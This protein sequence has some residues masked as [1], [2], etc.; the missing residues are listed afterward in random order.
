VAEVHGRGMGLVFAAVRLEAG[1]GRPVRDVTVAFE[2]PA[3]ADLFAIE[4]GWA[5]YVVCP[6]WFF[7]DRPPTHPTAVGTTGGR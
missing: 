7:T 1:P 2:S 3:A 5:D 4:S 6:L